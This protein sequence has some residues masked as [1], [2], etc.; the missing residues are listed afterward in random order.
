M[1]KRL[2]ILMFFVIVAAW[3]CPASADDGWSISKL[4]PFKKKPTA[5]KRARASFS[6]EAAGNSGFPRMS[7]PSWASRS[8]TPQRPKKPSTLAKLNQG[9]KDLYGKT[10]SVLMPWTNDSKKKNGSA[11]PKKSPTSILTSWLPKK[12]EKKR[13]TTLPDFIGRRRPGY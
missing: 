9:T 10:K 11:K 6:D 1:V 5:N 2:S 12:A 4:N 13:P 8:H 3:V 7:M